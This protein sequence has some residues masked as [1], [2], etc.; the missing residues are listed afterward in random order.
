MVFVALLRGINVGG[1][2]KIDMKLLKG[3]FAGLGLTNVVT[4]INTGNIIFTDSV[5][6]AT[7]LSAMLEEAIHND[8]GLTIKV[9]IRTLEEIKTIMDNIPDHWMNDKSM[10]SDVLYL[11]D[12]VNEESVLEKLII[13][14]EVDNVIYVKGAILWSYDKEH[15]GKSGMNKII[16]TKLYQRVTVRNVNTAR[17]IY[18]LM[19]AAEC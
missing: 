17:K 19:Q 2:N 18:E 10:K 7:E 15:A 12:D 1:N 13:K 8:F 3:T 16:G 6:S 14:P 5:H 4:Y 11:W 9:M